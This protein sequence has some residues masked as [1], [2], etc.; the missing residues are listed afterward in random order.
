MFDDDIR[1]LI[2]VYNYIFSENKLSVKLF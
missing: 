1:I 2:K